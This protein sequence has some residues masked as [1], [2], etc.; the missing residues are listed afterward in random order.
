MIQKEFASN[1]DVI[2]YR[3]RDSNGNDI[4]KEVKIKK[5]PLHEVDFVCS[6][7]HKSSNVGVMAKDI[8]SASFTDWAFLGG[9]VCERCADLF[10]L[11]FYNYIVDPSGIRLY[12]V[13][14]LRD[15]L[16]TVQKPPFLFVITTSKK[17]HLFYRAKWNYGGGKFAVNLETETIYTTPERMKHLFGFV[18]ALQTLGC[19]KDRMKRG[20]LPF[21]VLRKTGRGALFKLQRELA[22]SREIQIPL[23]CGQKLEIEEEEAICCINSTLKV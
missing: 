12:N 8:V 9:Y 17:K 11:Y 14:E 15:Q 22:L 13:R 1:N 10:S 5:F 23:Y 21:D 18:E 6:C 16:T 4:I 19:S 20:E 7:C 3:T 2:P